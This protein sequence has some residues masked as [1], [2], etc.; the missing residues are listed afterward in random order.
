LD[1]L[2]ANGH[3][4]PE[5][6]G[7]QVDAAYAERKYLYRNLRNGQ[8]EDV[9]L[10]GGLGIVAPVPA[11]GF[12]IGDY[13]N[14]GNLDAVV[15]C[16][17]GPPQLLHCQSTLNRSWIKIRVAGTK[18]NRTG[19]GARIKVVA[20]T[21]T[22]LLNEKPGSPLIQIDEVRSC[23]GY[24]SASDLRIHFGLGAAKKADSVE[25]RWPSGVVDIWKDLDVN[26]LYV[27]EEGGRILKTDGFASSRKNA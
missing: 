20:Q 7:T 4:Y 21:G 27:L 15:N 13:D 18:S 10:T 5:V 6:D 25:I 24:Y 23:N 22:P 26:R 1:I 3:V 2:V 17:N 19:I 11:R 12:A 14:D 16:V 9:S 8:F